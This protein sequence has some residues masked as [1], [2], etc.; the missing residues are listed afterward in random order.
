MK[1]QW[2]SHV[3]KALILMFGLVTLIFMV[4]IWPIV[5]Q[6]YLLFSPE[7]GYLYWPLLILSESLLILF[8]VGLSITM[9]LLVLYDRHQHISLRFVRLLRVLYS[10]CAVAAVVIA[11]VLVYLIF[12]AIVGPGESI[13]LSLTFLLVSVVG[14]VIYLIKNVI[15]ETIEYKQEMDMV[16]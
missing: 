7:L 12:F 6:Q 13:F 8:L 9:Y 5:A 2:I 16:I 3:L 11:G 15:S 14:S 10:L 4:S 1:K